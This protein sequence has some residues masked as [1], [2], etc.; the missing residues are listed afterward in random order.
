ML[1]D[2]LSYLSKKSARKLID[3]GYS[4]EEVADID[5]IAHRY[6]A[7]VKMIR[8]LMKRYSLDEIEEFYKIREDYT[9]CWFDDEFDEKYFKALQPTL[10]NISRVY[11]ISGHDFD[12]VMNF[13]DTV[14]SVCKNKRLSKK[15]IGSTVNSIIRA[16]EEF[17]EPVGVTVER[18]KGNI[19][20]ADPPDEEE[21]LYDHR[22]WK[23]L[24]PDNWDE[25]GEIYSLFTNR[26]K[27]YKHLIVWPWDDIDESDSP[28]N[29][30]EAIP[31]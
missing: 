13:L 29:E 18:F 7:S 10:K 27:S 9:D 4:P 23:L 26:R 3:N 6:K 14:L 24:Y 31:S 1:P 20:L 12:F 19:C 8:D 2:G 25:D 17:N 22:L 5:F 30:T 15:I 16:S 21:C 28:A 11:E